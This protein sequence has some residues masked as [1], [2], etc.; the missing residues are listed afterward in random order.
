MQ[1]TTVPTMELLMVCARRQLDAAQAAR[2][3]AITADP[4]LDWDTVLQSAGRHKMLPLL[5]AHL[6]TTG[7]Q[8]P[9]GVD[10][11]LKRYTLDNAQRVLAVTGELLALL[12]ELQKCGIQAVPYKG[13]VLALQL[14]GSLHLRP[15]GDMDVLVR[16]ADA[17]AAIHC[18]AGRGLLPAVTSPPEAWSFRL[19]NRYCETLQG[20]STQVELHW[21]FTNR[22]IAFPYELDDVAARLGTLR[23]SHQDVSVF[24]LEDLLLILCVHG[25]KHRWERLEWLAGVG[26]AVRSAQQMDWDALLERASTLGVRRMLLLGLLLSHEI[27]D[28]PVP[29]DVVARGRAEPHVAALAA[30]VPGILAG[31]VLEAGAFSGPVDS[32]RYRLRERFRD[33]ARFLMY[34]ATTPSRPEEWRFVSIAGRQFPLHAVTRPFQLTGRALARLVSS[35]NG[36]DPRASL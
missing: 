25:A 10:A 35:R 18:L 20:T 27:V 6:R 13:T 11:R 14:Y 7:A 12:Q 5:A 33:R 29:P 19:R 8:L 26:E 30:Q 1:L 28:A 2:V 32:F 3:R 34:R 31:P 36:G 16:R 9:P 21:A 4:Q 23:I 24:P 17:A 15:A 22:D